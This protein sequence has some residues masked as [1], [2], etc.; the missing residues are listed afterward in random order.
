M[1]YVKSEKLAKE[2]KMTIGEWLYSIEFGDG[3]SMKANRA[4][5]LEL[6]RWKFNHGWF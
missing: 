3:S 6:E 2:F 1:E 4:A 5:F